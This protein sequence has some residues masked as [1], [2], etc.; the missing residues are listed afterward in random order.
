[1]SG[2]EFTTMLVLAMLALGIA[3][4]VSAQGGFF[5]EVFEPVHHTHFTD[6]GTPFVHP[7]NF[8]P[9]QI[10]QDAFFIYKYTMNTI[11]GENEHEAETHI[12]WSLTKRLGI[13]LAAPLL[14]LEDATGTQSAG[15]GD[16]EI[17]PRA[18][19]IEQDKFILATNLFITVP[20]GHATRGLGTGE[21]V[22]SPAVRTS[23]HTCR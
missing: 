14:G 9:P 1:M 17:A 12:D 4:K 7:F 10:H 23:G 15:I 3:R 19:L 5:D 8:E 2:R 13:L 22:I 11:D 20:T 18:M 6:L 16:L 21:T